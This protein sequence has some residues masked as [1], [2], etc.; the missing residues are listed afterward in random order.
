MIQESDP[1]SRSEIAEK[2]T[3][4]P[5]TVSVITGELMEQGLIREC[6]RAT[7]T[8]GRRRILLEINPAGGYFICVDLG[9]EV[10]RIGVLDLSLD[11]VQTWSHPLASRNGEDLYQY[12]EDSIRA[13]MDWCKDEHI[14]MLGIGVA[15]PG[16]V[17]AERGQVIE[18]DN[19]NWYE[20]NLGE[21]LYRTFETKVV[22]ENDT[23][24]AAYGEYK[25]G[26]NKDDSV[27]NMIYVSVGSGIG[28][29]L[30]LDGKLYSGSSGMAGEIGHVMANPDGDTCSCG[31]RGCVE[32]IA[33]SGAIVRAYS[34]R[35]GASDPIDIL[36]VLR[37]AD[38]SS[39]IAGDVVRHA[40]RTMGVALGNLVNVVNV[41]RVLLNG[42][43]SHSQVMWNALLDGLN[44]A[45]LPQLRHELDVRQG[46]LAS[47]TG[48]VGVASLHLEKMVSLPSVFVNK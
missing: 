5:S 16:L 22:V 34:A 33:S 28:A 21:R 10:L 17:D 11:A 24:A 47:L 41:D 14:H 35:S 40:G 2:T 46:T 3:L 20:L 8:G 15:T 7:S 26:Y 29:G 43:T 38:S 48:L 9:G 25:F 19:L 23:N 4:A 36:T 37:L 6:G 31:K 27:S 30:V 44:Q 1:I 32:T 13:V 12:L 18:A 39:A 42:M 45:L